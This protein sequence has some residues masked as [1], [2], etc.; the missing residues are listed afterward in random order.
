MAGLG[1]SATGRAVSHPERRGLV[2][3][4]A[5]F[6]VIAWA[7]AFVGVRHAVRDLSPGPLTLLR[8]GVAALV[9]GIAVAIRGDALPTRRDLF[10]IVLCGVSWFGIYNVALNAGERTIDAG[11]AAMIVYIG[12]VLIAIL[13][14]IFLGEGFPRAVLVGC[15]VSFVGVVVIAAATSGGL[16]LNHGAL[17]C[18]LAAA[19]YAIGVVA[20]K[21]VLARRSSLMVT[22][23]ACMVGF[24]MCLP[25]TPTLLREVGRAPASALWSAVYLGVVPTAMAFTTWAYALTHRSAGR[26]ASISF[27]VPA[28]AVLQAWIVL[29]ETPPP[30]A[31]LGGALVLVGVAVAQRRGGTR[32]RD[33]AVLESRP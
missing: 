32:D 14:G 20:Q 2:V 9:L 8:L 31:Y 13:A 4:A 15:A 16:D 24:V 22:W 29:G 23:S 10:G 3:A 26:M 19:T 25:F 17:L 28:V 6:T 12:P 21:P 11:T 7:S 33:R 27:L 5:V 18:L 1:V 30:W